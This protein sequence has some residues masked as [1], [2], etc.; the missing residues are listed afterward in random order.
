M[1]IWKYNIPIDEATFT[2]E[3][4]EGFWP[5]AFQVQRVPAKAAKYIA[6]QGEPML[7][8]AV[9]PGDRKVRRRFHVVATGDET[10]MLPGDYIGTV[11]IADLVWHLFWERA[12]LS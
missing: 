5:L 10:T 9:N 1:K 6:Y 3:T 8:A 11:Q 12:A 4:P 7:W 2:M